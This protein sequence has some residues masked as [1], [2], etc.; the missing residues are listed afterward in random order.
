MNNPV[1]LSPPQGSA[2]TYYSMVGTV[3]DRSQYLF[4]RATSP[5]EAQ[6]SRAP[7][8]SPCSQGALRPETD[9][10][11]PPQLESLDP[12]TQSPVRDAKD[13][14]SP[15]LMPLCHAERFLDG[16]PLEALEVE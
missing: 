6:T 16:H 13:L 5:I 1:V 4:A 11:G 12:P 14:G 9:L 7:T 2:H 15:S 8:A 3:V 10:S